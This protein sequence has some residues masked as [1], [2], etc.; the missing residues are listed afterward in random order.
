MYEISDADKI[1]RLQMEKADG[2][3]CMTVLRKEIHRLRIL[4]AN[5]NIDADK[6][7][8][9]EILEAIAEQAQIW[10]ER[11]GDCTPNML[12]ICDIL[13]AKGW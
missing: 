1:A 9:R 10:R 6:S 11:G 4:L 12:R 2:E 5:R 3:R 7:G 13:K 8:C